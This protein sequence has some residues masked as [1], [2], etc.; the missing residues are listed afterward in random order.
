MAS[1]V[2]SQSLHRS[3]SWHQFPTHK[4]TLQNPVNRCS[5]FVVG[6]QMRQ[7]IAAK[8][9]HHLFHLYGLLLAAMP[10]CSDPS[11]AQVSLHRV[12]SLSHCLQ[13]LLIRHGS[14]SVLRKHFIHPL[15]TTLHFTTFIAKQFASW[16]GL[17]RQHTNHCTCSHIPFR[18]GTTTILTGF[19]SASFIA[20]S[21]QLLLSPLAAHYLARRR[22]PLRLR[23]ACA[24]NCS[25]RTS[26][27]QSI[28]KLRLH[29]SAA[30][31]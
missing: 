8:S 12:C 5:S 22:S 7:T 24:A 4:P 6:K 10:E 19:H 15:L 3:V 29:S 31:V 26:I 11:Q 17:H 13:L 25:C 30:S 23:L 27:S 20:T 9:K 28:T 21:F 2:A 14:S 18:K 16:H 1:P